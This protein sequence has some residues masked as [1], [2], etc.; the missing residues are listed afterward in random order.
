MENIKNKIIIIGDDNIWEITGNK[1]I[2]KGFKD[3]SLELL[4]IIGRDITLE[5][6]L[7]V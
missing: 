4:E 2:Y 1:N 3:G 5:D 6:V 7:G